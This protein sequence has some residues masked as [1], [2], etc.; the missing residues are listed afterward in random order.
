MAKGSQREKACYLT[1]RMKWMQLV[2]FFALATIACSVEPGRSFAGNSKHESCPANASQTDAY[3]FGGMLLNPSAF[4]TVNSL[5]AAG[6]SVHVIDQMSANTAERVRKSL[7]REHLDR[8]DEQLVG[9]G[10]DLRPQIKRIYLETASKW[11]DTTRQLQTQSALV[12]S[13]LPKSAADPFSDEVEDWKERYRENFPAMFPLKGNFRYRVMLR[14]L[15]L[16][17]EEDGVEIRWGITH[18]KYLQQNRKGQRVEDSLIIAVAPAASQLGWPR[19]GDFASEQ[20]LG[21]GYKV[22]LLSDELEKWL[23]KG[24]RAIVLTNLSVDRFVDAVAKSDAL[25]LD[26]ERT[27][28]TNSP[29]ILQESGLETFVADSEFFHGNIIPSVRTSGVG[30]S[31]Q[32]TEISVLTVIPK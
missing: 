19:E 6:Y 4:L 10:A 21:D 24:S 26:D 9:F 5:R 13:Q 25:Q 16:S 23:G 18:N 31:I 20:I 32:G 22:S 14:N 11:S 3:V 29:S 2:L 7:D 15:G 27:Y 28:V 8:V 17:L 30:V 1:H 12:Q